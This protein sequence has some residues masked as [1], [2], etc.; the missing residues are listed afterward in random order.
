MKNQPGFVSV[1]GIAVAAILVAVVLGTTLIAGPILFSPG[2]LNAKSKSGQTIGGV[3]THAQLAGKCEACHSAPWS[4]QT[5]VDRC[6]ACHTDVGTQ[7]QS[8][9]GLHG[10]LVGKS[11]SPTCKGCHTDHRGPSGA[12][13][14]ADESTFPHDTTGYSL[15]G[16]QKKSNGTRFACADCHPKGVSQFDQATCAA[17]HTAIDAKFM[18]QHVTEFGTQCLG[19]HDGRRTNFKHDVFPLDHGSR[20]EKATCETCHPNRVFKSYTC[21]GCHRHTPANV[22]GDHEGQSLAQLQDCVRCHP[23]GRQ[24]DN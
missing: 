22:V 4:P 18:S 10:A 3:T 15:R 14:V 23:Q 11:Q 9:T 7:I 2:S 20:E 19:C 5:M 13:T 16:H 1:A 21:F 24:G 17:C 12:L 8:K 6:V